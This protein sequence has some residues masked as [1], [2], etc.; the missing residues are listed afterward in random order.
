TALRL[1]TSFSLHAALPICARN[2]ERQQEPPAQGGAP[3]AD[4]GRYRIH[5]AQ[6][7]L[8]Q[9]PSRWGCSRFRA[10]VVESAPV[11][12]AGIAAEPPRSEEHTSELQSRENLVCR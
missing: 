11:V 3:P 6:S 10:D 12:P 2:R 9:R 1:T 7:S 5:G 8:H 4:V